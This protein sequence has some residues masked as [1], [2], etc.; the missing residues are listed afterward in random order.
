MPYC[1]V[2][3]LLEWCFKMKLRG[4]CLIKK[5][6]KICSACAF[7]YNSSFPRTVKSTWLLNQPESLRAS[8]ARIAAAMSFPISLAKTAGM[9]TVK[10]IK[11]KKFLNIM[12]RVCIK[13][14]ASKALIFISGQI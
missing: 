9:E 14:L 11:I 8:P 3:G 6:R 2:V 13:N 10:N 4:G 5:S 7:E 12:S 1:V